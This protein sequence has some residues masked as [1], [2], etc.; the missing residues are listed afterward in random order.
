[1]SKKIYV[2]GAGV[3]CLNLLTEQAKNIIQTA[4]LVIANN[5][6]VEAFAPLNKNTIC[7][8]LNQLDDIIISAKE[9][10]ICVL[11]SGDVG[12]Y[13]ISKGLT[14]RFTDVTLINGIGSLQYFAAKLKISYD[15]LKIVSLHGRDT[16]IIPYVSYNKGVFALTGGK[17]L[18]H[19]IISQ[20]VD[21]GLGDVDIAVG[22]NLS[23]DDE[24]ITQGTARQLKNITF[25]KLAVMVI[26]NN[27]YVNPFTR[28]TDDM[29]IRA[30][31]PMTK[32]DVR[33]LSIAMLDI[34]P[35]DIV[36]DIGAG[37]G[38]VA[39]EM[40]RKAFEGTVYGIEHSAEALNLISQNRLK[41]GAYNLNVIDGLAPEALTNLPTP[42]RAFIGGSQGNLDK[43]VELLKDK[44]PLIKIVINAVTL[45]TLHFATEVLKTNGFNTNVTCL[46]I[47]TSNNLGRYTMLKAQNPLFIIYGEPTHD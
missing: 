24:K 47:S 34:Q 25:S 36:Y 18:A 35:S 45:E 4:Q 42:Q 26:T 9:E 13:S 6:L 23:L 1:M 15:S 39:I 44:N 7:A 10:S 27:N 46:N 20:L 21:C 30:N 33:T 14:E 31:V 37:T 3:G 2:V 19:D 8:E 16:S 12:F 32:Q 28:I 40:C 17:Y 22:E 5:R 29:F 38:S 41:H 43:I 11:A